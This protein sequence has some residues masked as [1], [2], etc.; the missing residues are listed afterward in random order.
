MAAKPTIPQ[1]TRDFDALTVRR[2]KFILQTIEQ[3]FVKYGYM[4]LETPSME[5]L[6]TLTGKYGDEGDQLLF[7]IL[8]TGDYLKKLK[9]YQ[10][11]ASGH[12]ELDQ[13][14]SPSLDGTVSSL[15][16]KKMLPFIA[17]KGLRYDLTVPFAR[18]VV[19]NRNDIT[20][21]Y[22]RYQMQP[23]W[24]ADRPQRGRYR[25]FW[26]CDADVI[27]SKSLINEAELLK[28]YDEAFSY[29]NVPVNIRVNNRKL[30]SGL[31]SKIN[32][33]DKF[34]AL[35]VAL[36]KLDKTGESGLLKDL[37]NA[38]FSEEQSTLVMEFISLSKS[39]DILATLT[40][41]FHD[42][43]EGLIG[44]SELTQM[45]DYAS[46]L[47]IKNQLNIDV[48]LARGLSYYTGAIV[49]VVANA[50]NFKPSIGGGG[51]YDNLTGIFGLPDV[52]GV[53]ISFGLDRIYDVL[54]E[55]KLF[56]ENLRQKETMLLF[57]HFDEASQLHALNLCALA[58]NAGVAAE[59]YPDLTKKIA[60]Q[61]EYANKNQIRYAV[62][63]GS[64]EIESGKYTRKDL[65]SGTQV[66]LSAT[67]LFTQL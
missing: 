64:N 39:D 26:Q 15:D 20:F 31:A 10:D 35:T 7:K 57:C 25:E 51:R 37:E 49:E 65:N 9:E 63:I 16:S 59:V 32:A 36:D 43:P 46:L 45:L 1:G 22:K 41:F 38:G 54:E 56:P 50:G 42:S 19:M 29:L 61:L 58:R 47:G 14:F 27:G 5:N 2:R 17:E 4:P 8:N 66:E 60:K 28:M 21:P 24:R 62:I 3:V 30:L 52:S 53:G 23:V 55:L 67:Q 33:A 48:T 18:Y 11:Q 12:E 44:V 40:N 34:T 6:Q 13:T